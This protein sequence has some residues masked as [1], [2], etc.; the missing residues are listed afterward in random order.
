MESFEGYKVK[1][2]ENS[3]RSCFMKIIFLDGKFD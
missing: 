2:V 3:I 1:K